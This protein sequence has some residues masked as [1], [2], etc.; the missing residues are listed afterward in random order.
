MILST[1]PVLAGTARLTEIA[2]G[3][4]ITPANARFMASAWPVVLH[5]VAV[6]IYSLLGAW[7]FC[8]GLRR[9]S[10]AWHRVAGRVVVAAGML[11]ATTGLW[12]TQRYPWPTGD[13][14]ALYMER[15]LFGTAMLVSLLLALAAIRRRDF[16]AHGQWMIRAYA[17][18]LGAGTQVFTHLPWLLLVKS[19]PGE[20]PRAVMM[21]AGWI[22]NVVVA[23]WIVRRQH[24]R[25]NPC[26]SDAISLSSNA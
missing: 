7:Q 9:R 1:V 18:G 15:L 11:A 26:D 22:I 13:G 25:R 17:I 10:R 19:T 20:M 12:M 14:R 21:G 24:A 2:R 3:A 5:I 8:N 4:A 16:T 23:E 6:S